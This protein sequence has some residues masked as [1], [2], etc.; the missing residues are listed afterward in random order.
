MRRRSRKADLL[1]PKRMR[2]IRKRADLL[3]SEMKNRR[4]RVNLFKATR[5]S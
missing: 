4:W 3:Q 5:S 2:R 1:Q